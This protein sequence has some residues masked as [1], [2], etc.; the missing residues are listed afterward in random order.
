[1]DANRL[2][3][4]TYY[5]RVAVYLGVAVTL[6]VSD[7]VNVEA[8]RWVLVVIVIAFPHGIFLV[9]RHCFNHANG[10]RF[11]MLADGLLVGPLIV[12]MNFNLLVSVCMA[13]CL[14][15]GTL[16]IC[17][18]VMLLANVAIVGVICGV[19]FQPAHG[20]V[21]SW[22][23]EVIS[24]FVL[25]GFSG[26]VAFLCFRYT[27]TLV[28]VHRAV[29]ERHALQQSRIRPYIS[30]Q[31]L[32]SITA[33]ETIAS[34]RKHLTVFF[35]D[36]EGFTNLM[37]Q[38]NEN[39]IT[40][41]L[42]EYLNEMSQIAYRHGGTVD[43][44]MGDG[45][46]MLFGQS[47][48]VSRDAL[49]CVKMAL[50]M[51][52]KLNELA[53]GWQCFGRDLHIRIGIH[54]GFCRVGNFGSSAR[55]EYTAVGSTVNRGSRLEGCADTDEIL[56]SGATYKLIQE[57]INCRAKPPVMVKGI[58]KPIAIFSVDSVKPKRITVGSVRLL[59]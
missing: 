38:L 46:M 41:L 58:N 1:M 43:K 5:P 57:E 9:S 45:V 17:R 25:L 48:D 2:I 6:L 3:Q 8:A 27:S 49:N 13:T 28:D 11:S 33:D 55:M 59:K 29:G 47:M 20:P 40:R 7:T 53:L 22:M 31:V 51:R 52:A 21:G 23:Q 37:D 30:E 26:F 10:A 56:I 54:S 24:V 50:A 16:L 42:N 15:M 14:V 18:P 32:S 34:K 19:F 44:F 4:F 35:S 36:I 12:A 39:T